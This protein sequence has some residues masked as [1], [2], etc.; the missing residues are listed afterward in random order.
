MSPT[1]GPARRS[2]TGRGLRDPRRASV[3]S[4]S[5]RPRHIGIRVAL[6]ASGTSVMHW[7]TGHGMRIGLL[8]VGAGLL[9]AF[10]VGRMVLSLPFEST[11]FDPLVLAVTA[12]VLLGAAALACVVPGLRATRVNPVTVLASD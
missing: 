10:S 5:I 9:L 4:A 7:A 8:G 1:H 11:P 12:L 6:W 3:T 2:A